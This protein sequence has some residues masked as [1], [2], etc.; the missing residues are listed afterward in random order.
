MRRGGRGAWI[1]VLQ[2]SP[3]GAASPESPPLT[4]RDEKRPPSISTLQCTDEMQK[5]HWRGTVRLGP[6]LSGGIIN[7]IDAPNGSK[8][9]HGATHYQGLKSLII[10]FSAAVTC[11][12]HPDHGPQQQ[13]FFP[14]PTGGCKHAW[15]PLGWGQ[16]LL[17]VLSTY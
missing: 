11:C 8:K 10:R 6:R 9:D 17:P 13:S 12:T 4:N 14:W 5:P 15:P 16:G 1:G 2:A 7:K 3:K